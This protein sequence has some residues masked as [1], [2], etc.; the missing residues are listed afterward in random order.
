MNGPN[1][2]VV[3]FFL[4]TSVKRLLLSLIPL[5]RYDAHARTHIYTH[6]NTPQLT[7]HF[8][9]L[10]VGLVKL[11]KSD[12][13]RKKLCCDSFRVHTEMKNPKSILFPN[14]FSIPCLVVNVHRQMSYETLLF[15]ITALSPFLLLTI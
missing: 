11:G 3:I 6:Q 4:V 2:A 9:L 10:H 7:D 14:P 15:R 13:K 8:T 12:V 1:A 5:L